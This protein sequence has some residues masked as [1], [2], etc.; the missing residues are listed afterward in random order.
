M[1]P[2]DTL[3]TLKDFKQKSLKEINNPDWI[4]EVTESNICV[5]QAKG[6]LQAYSNVK[7]EAIKWYN[8]FQS[9]RWENVNGH[10][11]FGGEISKWIQNFFNISEDDLK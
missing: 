8:E 7:Q 11:D 5:E 3:R 1:P 4:G 10:S 6:E 2:K 9:E